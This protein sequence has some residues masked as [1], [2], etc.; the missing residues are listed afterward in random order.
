MSEA[1]MVQGRQLETADIVRIRQL[2]SENPTWSR[3]RL[4][5][6]IAQEWGWRNGS[7]QLKDMAART[8]LL[9]L[10]ARG[11]IELPPRRRTPPIRMAQGRISRR[12]WDTTP[13]A[14]TLRQ[15]GPLTIQEISNDAA[16]RK[17]FAAALAEFHYLG[18]RGT[19]GENVQYVVADATGRLLSCLLFGAPAW[20]CKS[21]DEF[22]GWS[23]AERQ[24]RLSYITNNTRFLILPFVRVPHLAS[25]ILGQALRRLSQDWQRKYGHPILLVETFVERDRFAGTSYKAANWIRIGSTTGRSRQDRNHRLQVPV[26]DVYVYPLHHRFREELSA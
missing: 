15:L 24:R 19:V 4:S 8:M 1:V 26:K 5:E 10:D 2:V 22:I 23:Q 7:G 18:Y 13:V 25:W 11:L 21:R 20:K 17:R 12:D 16:E 14:R 9:K 6:V 3:R